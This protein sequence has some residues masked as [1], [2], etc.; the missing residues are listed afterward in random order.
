METLTLCLFLLL[1]FS[2]ITV[3][4]TVFTDESNK[5]M[6]RENMNNLSVLRIP[7]KQKSH[8]RIMK[9][10][11]TQSKEVSL[12]VD[13]LVDVATNAWNEIRSSG[14]AIKVDPI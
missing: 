7:I 3:I 5:M 4:P 13:A 10:N 9:S 1:V 6:T 8:K 11:K 14:Q 2:V 12:T